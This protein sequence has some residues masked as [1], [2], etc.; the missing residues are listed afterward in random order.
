[1][2][3]VRVVTDSACDLTDELARQHGIT[4]VP[5]T[6]RFGDEELLDRRDLSPAEF[7]RRCTGQPDA[8]RDGRPAPGC[9]PGRLRGGSRRRGRRRGVPHHLLGRLG[10]LPV[11]PGRRRGRW[12]RLPVEVVDTRSVTMGQ[13]LLCLAAAEAAA[14][15]ATLDE[16]VAPGRPSSSAGPGSRRAGHP[17]PPPAG[18]PDRRGRGPAWARSSRSSRSSRSRRRG[19]PGVQAAHPARARSTTWRTRPGP[20]A[21]LERLAVCNGA[22]DDIDDVVLAPERDRGRGPPSWSWSTSGRW[23]APTPARAPSASAI[24][25][26]VRLAGP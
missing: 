17:G 4:V 10:H 13:G 19:R 1:M 15:G 20:T 11:G 24:S 16:V 9:L 3:G 12:P 6:I 2:A 25:S 18:R 5:L 21:P 22:A 8:A 26:P 23:S 7:W 14:A